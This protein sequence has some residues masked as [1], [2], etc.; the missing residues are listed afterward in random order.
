ML[1]EE[2]LSAAEKLVARKHPN[3]WTGPMSEVY[4]L[5]TQRDWLCLPY[6]DKNV[7]Q[8]E[9]NA[10][11]LR[12]VMSALSYKDMIVGV[13]QVT[14]GWLLDEQTGRRGVATNTMGKKEVLLFNG[15]GPAGARVRV[16]E[17]ARKRGRRTVRRLI[18]AYDSMRKAHGGD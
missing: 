14:T 2:L 12:A 10:A 11:K 7:S 13:V 9:L 4:I 15:R 3:G 18:G 17:V 1:T 8:A 6:M 16:Y 5:T